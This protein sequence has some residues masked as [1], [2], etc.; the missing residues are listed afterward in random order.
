MGCLKQSYCKWLAAHTLPDADGQ[1]MAFV[2]LVLLVH[3][4]GMLYLTT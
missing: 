1:P 3:P 2:F 4:A